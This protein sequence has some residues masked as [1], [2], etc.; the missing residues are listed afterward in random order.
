MPTFDLISPQQI[1]KKK[2]EKKKKKEQ[3]QEQE[4]GGGNN[5]VCTY[6][7]KYNRVSCLMI[8]KSLIS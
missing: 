3:E 1:L 6:T 5:R 2:K 7:Y 4:K 8:L